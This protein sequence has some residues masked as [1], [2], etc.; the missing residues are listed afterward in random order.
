[1]FLVKNTRNHPPVVQQSMRTHFNPLQW[2]NTSKNYL[3]PDDEISFNKYLI[4]HPQKIFNKFYKHFETRIK[5]LESNIRTQIE[6]LSI[7]NC[8]E[9]LNLISDFNQNLFDIL[10]SNIQ[11]TLIEQLSE[12][13]EQITYFL[14]TIAKNH[15]LYLKQY[16]QEYSNCQVQYNQYHQR[17]ISVQDD[18]IKCFLHK[19]SSISL[20]LEQI[21]TTL[22]MT[23]IFLDNIPLNITECF[24]YYTLDDDVRSS[25]L[26]NI[27]N[28]PS[29]EACLLNQIFYFKQTSF[30]IVHEIVENSE[31]CIDFITMNSILW[32]DCFRLK[33]NQLIDFFS[34][35]NLKTSINDCLLTINEKLNLTEHHMYL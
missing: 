19:L 29:P 26:I 13:N 9:S 32:D 16:I 15:D 10:I 30:E 31:K 22:H 35:M 6:K 23:D 5:N 25:K 33:T 14:Q 2:N 17:V 3:L 24:F 7:K 8:E 18:I 1:M 11:N 12:L 27:L 34:L 4:F 21:L 20:Q 28:I